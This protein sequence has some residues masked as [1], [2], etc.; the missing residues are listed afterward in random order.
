MY[1]STGQSFLKRNPIAIILMETA[2]MIPQGIIIVSRTIETKIYRFV[3]N[4]D[5]IY[6]YW[7]RIPKVSYWIVDL[8]HFFQLFSLQRRVHVFVGR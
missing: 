3:T 1:F 7:C 8:P 2:M 5:E 4:V 6:D